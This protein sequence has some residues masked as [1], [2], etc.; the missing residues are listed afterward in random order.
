MFF[1]E[2]VANVFV[3]AAN[4]IRK[5]WLRCEVE[6]QYIP[7]EEAPYRNVEFFIVNPDTIPIRKVS[8]FSA[9]KHI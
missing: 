5:L 1:K 3:I 7:P 4:Q 6:L 9:T 2:K 8:F